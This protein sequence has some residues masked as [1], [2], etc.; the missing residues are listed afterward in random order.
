MSTKYLNRSLHS[1][2]K[3]NLNIADQFRMLKYMNINEVKNY[4]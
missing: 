2:S 4:I 3:R 1:L